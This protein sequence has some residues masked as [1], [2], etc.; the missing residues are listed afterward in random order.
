MASDTLPIQH[1][2]SEQAE[3]DKSMLLLALDTTERGAFIQIQDTD[4]LVL[5]LWIY[6]RL[7]L[8]T[9][10]IA[11]TRGK[12]RSIPLGPCYEVVGEDLVRA[13]PG[14]HAFSWLM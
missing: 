14:F 2:R 4:V 9:K 10:A 8:D 11:E 13:L 7:C 6:K 3:A 5:M 12:G 1:L